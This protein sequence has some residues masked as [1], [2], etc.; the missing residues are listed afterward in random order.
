MKHLLS[1]LSFAVLST[2]TCAHAADLPSDVLVKSRWMQLTRAD[3]EAALSRVPED[4]RFEFAA[5]PKRVQAMLNNLLVTKTLAAQA[6]LDGVRPPGPLGKSPGVDD[7]QAL[8]TA[9]L[10]HVDAD[11][12]Q[13]FDARKDAFEAQARE[14]YKLDHDKYRTPEEVR[15]SD[16][17]VAI[18]GRGDDAARA[19]AEDA[20]RRVM[21]GEDFAAVARE[22]SDDPTT[23][24]KGGALPFVTEKGLAPA[25]AKAVFA[26][27]K[28]GEVSMPIKAP[29]AWH[30]VRLEERHPSRIAT[31]DEVRDT[32]MQGLRQKYVAERREMRIASIHRDPELQMNQPAIDALVT[33]VDPELLKTPA[34]I[35]K[36]LPAGK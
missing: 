14:L 27:S 1:M 21:A 10:R 11:A 5:D 22:Y 17:A 28:I 2:L 36:G 30:V 9:E 33:H 23:K 12:N 4:K 16:I 7:D 8:A 15:L 3:Y 20:R 18:K 29:A 31:F 35:G 26:L 13:A 25:Y 34:K 6:R 32:I 19:R 24:D